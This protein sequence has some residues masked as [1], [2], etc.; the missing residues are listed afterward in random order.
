MS[1][2][3]SPLFTLATDQ[4]A[5]FVAAVDDVVRILPNRPP[6]PVLGAV[7]VET[8]SDGTVRLSGFDYDCSISVTL[9]AETAHEARALVSGRLLAAVKKVLPQQPLS[10]RLAPSSLELRTGRSEFVLPLLPLD[11]YPQLPTAG[12]ISGYIDGEAFIAEV[13]RAAGFASKIAAGNDIVASLAAV[14]VEANGDGLAIMA[15][16]RFRVSYAHTDWS[17]E[18]PIT[19]PIPVMVDSVQIT[20]IARSLRPDDRVALHLGENVFAVS[21]PGCVATSRLIAG[22]PP[23]YRRVMVGEYTVAIGADRDELHDAVKR[24]AVMTGD[25]RPAITLLVENDTLTIASRATDSLAGAG[26]AATEHLPVTVLGDDRV[27]ID[28]N[29]TLFS[30]AIAAC[31]PG[32][33]TIGFPAHSSRAFGI[34]PG[35]PFAG[36]PP[37]PAP[38]LPY[39]NILMPIRKAS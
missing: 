6:V 17:P 8:D 27:D 31:P 22:D 12:P 3:S 24:A 11:D 19:D 5:Q 14:T 18:Q 1:A 38:D 32:P 15:T 2:N 25:Q 20:A 4:V 10:A 7:L 21:T 34:H 39:R 37:F 29:A 9:T 23:P 33:I 35:T 16:D 28:C 26:G 36:T 30:A 13:T